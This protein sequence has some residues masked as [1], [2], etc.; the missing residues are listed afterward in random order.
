MVKTKI[1][2]AIA[3]L[4]GDSNRYK[5]DKGEISLVYPC[6]VTMDRYEIYCI[7]GDLF[8][9]VE[10]YDTLDEAETRITELLGK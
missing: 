3:G 10:R 6:K 5:T 1:S 4:V 9:D 8:D 2:S 7:S